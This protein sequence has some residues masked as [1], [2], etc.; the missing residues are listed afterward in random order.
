MKILLIQTVPGI[1]YSNT[2]NNQQ[3]GIA[4]AFIKSRIQCDILYASNNDDVS[5]FEVK[6]YGS[7]KIYSVKSLKLFKNCFIKDNIKLYDSYDILQ[8][9]EY[10]QIYAWHLAKKYRDKVVI[11]HGPYYSSFNKNYNRMAKIFDVLFT[12]RYKHLNTKFITKSNLAKKYLNEKGLSNVTTIGVGIDVFALTN[13]IDTKIEFVEEIKSNSSFSYRILYVGKLEP[14]RNVF[15]LLDLLKELK[16]RKLNACLIIIGT[17][18]RNY[19]NKFFEKAK[20]YNL[21]D[22]ILYKDKIDQK[23]MCQIYPLIDAFLLPTLY[24]I[25]GMVLLEAMYFSRIVFTTVNGGSDMLINDKYNGFVFSDFNINAWCDSIESILI[26]P[27]KKDEIGRRAHDTIQNDY[28]WEV[29]I[30]RF[31]DIYRAK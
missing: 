12:P 15:F 22:S 27:S 4:S 30:K 8:P 18:E 23:Y 29:L 2:Y 9:I 11:Y 20:E 31:I 7:I 17:G 1:I 10:N 5:E 3:I 6:G 28:T 14:R 24:D 26:D 16:N 21:Y 25:F 19:V 13:G